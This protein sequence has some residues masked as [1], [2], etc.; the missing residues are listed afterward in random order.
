M[1]RCAGN[2]TPKTRYPGNLGDRGA[3]ARSGNG[4]ERALPVWTWATSGNAST[5]PRRCRDWCRGRTPN[6]PFH[7]SHGDT[8]RGRGRWRRSLGQG[9]RQYSRSRGAT[10]CCSCEAD[11]KPPEIH[12]IIWGCLGSQPKMASMNNH[13]LCT[14][15]FRVLRVRA[16]AQDPITYSDLGSDVGVHHRSPVLHNALGS[17]WGW[18][19]EQGL[20]HINALV[21]RK[22]GARRN[23]PGTGDRPDGN[24]VTR[25]DWFAIRDRVYAY[26]RWGQLDPPEKWPKG[27]TEGAPS[28]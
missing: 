28:Q 17:I 23:I 10:L 5:H 21:V 14:A 20:P 13:D 16:L 18:C 12:R 3:A 6:Q 11:G 4:S 9:C 19:A 7:G 27:Y 2:S 24:P 22:S 25:A 15:I 1:Q 26:A 8:V